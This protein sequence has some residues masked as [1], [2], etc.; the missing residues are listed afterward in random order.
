MIMKWGPFSADIPFQEV[1][2]LDIMLLM[3]NIHIKRAPRISTKAFPDMSIS[4]ARFRNGRHINV[5]LQFLKE[6][7]IQRIVHEVKGH[8]FDG[9]IYSHFW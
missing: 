2:F 5:F 4:K 6:K 3:H 1:E 9:F 7:E 8:E